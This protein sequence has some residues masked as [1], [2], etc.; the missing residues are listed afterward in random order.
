MPLKED[1]LS[2]VNE[3]GTKFT[4]VD[5]NCWQTKRS[6]VSLD[7]LNNLGGM[8][9]AQAKNAIA[10]L[11][12]MEK[13]YSTNSYYAWRVP[14]REN[15]D[16]YFGGKPHMQSVIYQDDYSSYY[17][18]YYKWLLLPEYA[19]AENT[20]MSFDLAVAN[21]QGNLFLNNLNG[22]YNAVELVNF[23]VIIST[24]GGNSFTELKRIDLDECDS[25]FQRVSVDLT[26]YA[27]QNVV[28]GF[29]HPMKYSSSL[30][31]TP[32]I[33][34]A[35]LRLNCYEAYAYE[36]N[37]CLGRDYQDKGF[38]IAATELPAVGEKK[39]FERLG[40]AENGCDS[41]I[42]LTLEVFDT[43][44]DTIYETICEGESYVFGGMTL[45]QSNPEG[46]PYAFNTESSVGCDS[47]TYLYLTVAPVEVL[48]VDTVITTD[49]LPFIYEGEEILDANTSVGTY[50]KELE[51]EGTCT[52]IKL[53]IRVDQLSAIDRV[54]MGDLRL[55]PTIVE[56][57]GAINLELG[58][59]NPNDMT[60]EVYDALGKRIAT[61]QPTTQVMTL[62]DFQTSGVFII[63][64]SSAKGEAF[65]EH[66]LVK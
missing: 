65:V 47:I 6:T 30:L 51:V 48:T 64:V 27:D 38:S 19:V 31:T 61:Y 10:D 46:Q 8:A 39:A 21:I 24:D 58:T 28:L 16:N 42:T 15:L 32:N 66:V 52:T 36:D 20:K 62:K 40:Y 3:Y 22:K 50:T 25:T 18:T 59:M 35:D 43:R 4:F 37:V 54:T 53:S 44:V 23:S 34:I 13:Y 41:T 29:Y 49:Q 45:T 5:A 57:G 1:F 11:L 9:T 60:V 33:C 63:K 12:L 14:Y 17:G 7:S 56:V 55:Y 26:T 2:Y